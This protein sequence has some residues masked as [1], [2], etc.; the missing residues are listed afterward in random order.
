M[1]T[2]LLANESFGDGRYANSLFITNY[3]ILLWGTK[4]VFNLFLSIKNK[5][6]TL[7]QRTY[8]NRS[9]IDLHSKSFGH[10]NRRLIQKIKHLNPDFIVTTGD[11][12]TSTDESGEVFLNVVESLID[13]VSHLLY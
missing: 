6:T 11:M 3:F 1:M 2:L 7:N 13:Q 9:F 10:Q 12:I 8:S 4:T 5:K